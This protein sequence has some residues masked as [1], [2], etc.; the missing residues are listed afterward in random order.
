MHLMPM[1]LGKPFPPLRTRCQASTPSASGACPR[2]PVPSRHWPVRTAPGFLKEFSV[3]RSP[4]GHRGFGSR[5]WFLAWPL[6]APAALACQALFVLQSEDHVGRLLCCLR[7]QAQASRNA[8]LCSWVLV[9]G[10]AS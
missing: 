5:V 1:G 2:H 10:G 6:S 7:V 8:G 3:P 9:W 4:G